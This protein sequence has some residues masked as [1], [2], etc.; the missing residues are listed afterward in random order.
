MAGLKQT[1]LADR[2]QRAERSPHKAI[3]CF[4]CGRS[5]ASRPS[6]GDDSTRFC[7]ANCR[8]AYDADATLAAAEPVIFAGKWRV[9]AGPPPGHMPQ[10]MQSSGSGFLI[11]CAQCKREFTS[12]G[13]RYCSREC[14]R[15]HKDRTETATILAEVG[16]GIPEK[17]KCE[18]CGAAMP[19]WIGEGTKRRRTPKSRRYCSDRC[20]QKARK[21]RGSNS[22]NAVETEPGCSECS[23]RSEPSIFGPSTPPLNVLG[24]YRWPDAPEPEGGP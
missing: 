12:T 24:G 18:T 3:L 16:D 13:L 21:F 17:R 2:K 9:V 10:L 19:N 11:N 6:E 23:E 5:Y 14:E 7:S 1:I 4:A 15:A 8:E 22:L 20:R